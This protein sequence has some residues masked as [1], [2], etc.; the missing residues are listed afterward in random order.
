LLVILGACGGAPR[1]PGCEAEAT[2]SLAMREAFAVIGERG[3]MRRVPGN[4][5]RLVNSQ[6]D[7]VHLTAG[8]GHMWVRTGDE[9]G[10]A[11]LEHVRTTGHDPDAGTWTCAAGFV[12]TFL[13]D[14]PDGIVR[15]PI[16]YRSELT[17]PPGPHQH[18]VRV[19]LAHPGG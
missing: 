4:P 12:V 18:V 3:G 14:R 8:G 7:T 6:G 1:A 19:V 11:I 5:D 15:S 16:E 10:A 9:R 2:T 13:V 17:P